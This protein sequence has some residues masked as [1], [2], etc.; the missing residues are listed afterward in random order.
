MIVIKD[1][2][3][4]AVCEYCGNRQTLPRLNN[5]EKSVLV[6]RAEMYRQSGDYDKAI[7]LYEKTLSIEKSDPDVY[8]ALALCRYG[9][10]FVRDPRTGMA[11]PTVNRT[12]MTP[13]SLDKDYKTALEYAD[14]QQRSL[15]EEQAKRI[16]EIQKNILKISKN[17]QPF[18]VFICYK[19]NDSN[20]RRTHESANAAQMYHLLCREGYKVFFARITLEDKIGAAYEPYIFS[21]L[22]S[23]KVMIVVGTSKENFE[24]PWVRNEWSRYL[25]MIQSGENKTLIPAYRDMDPYE[26]PQE[27]AYLQALDMNNLGFMHDLLHA[28]RKIIPK[29]AEQPE[30]PVPQPQEDLNRRCAESLLG[31]LQNRRLRNSIVFGTA[32][33]YSLVCAVVCCSVSSAQYGTGRSSALVFAMFF[34]AATA[35]FAFNA[36]FLAVKYNKLIKKYR[37]PNKLR[38]KEDKE[39]VKKYYSGI[40]FRRISAELERLSKTF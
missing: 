28:I 26:L 15:Y 1:D 32:A 10:L 5:N 7:E 39:M 27:F 13:I 36:V 17:E 8:W 9:I 23:A 29:K 30:V 22:Q 18:D 11:V 21:A 16:D 34:F 37:F 38:Y 4:T 12:Q 33:F 40:D 35:F 24:A 2:Q 25:A 19:E 6:E 14:F 3:T 20:G 31:T